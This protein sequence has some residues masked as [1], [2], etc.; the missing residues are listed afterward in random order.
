[1]QSSPFLIQDQANQSFSNLIEEALFQRNPIIGSN[2]QNSNPSSPNSSSHIL[3]FRSRAKVPN[4][5]NTSIQS[6]F[7]NASEST[8]IQ[9]LRFISTAPEKILDAP[10]ILND[11]Y[12]NLMDWGQ[13]NLL[14]ISLNQNLYLWNSNNGSIHLLLS[15]P[16]N[17]ITSVN[18]MKTGV[19]LAVGFSNSSLQLWDIENSR[20]L[21]HLSGHSSRV[22]SLSWNNY[23]LSSGS[24]DTMILNHDVRSRSN[25]IS[26]Y[27]GHSQEVCGLKWSL[28]YSYLASGSNDNNLF[29]W[30]LYNK[31]PKIKFLGHKAAV[32][33]VAWCPWQKAVIASG[34][35]TADKC[36]KFWNCDSEKLLKN[37]ETDSQ[38]SSLIWNRFENEILSSHGYLNNQI[39][40]WK[41]PKMQNVIELKGHMNRILQMCESPDGETVVSAGADETLRFWKVF[42]KKEKKEYKDEMEETYFKRNNLPIR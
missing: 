28:D 15:D 23:V 17:Q 24:K 33:A 19:C 11:Y 34:G 32:K 20:P 31:I 6:N 29:I 12:L 30:D 26:K 42:E 3:S 37:H 18:F 36:I 10:E 7:R 16:N 27:L 39:S 38:V 1:M 40:L 4:S 5:L 21:R 14:A 25:V 13:T 22:S 9:K 2:F 41:Y 35:G 8:D